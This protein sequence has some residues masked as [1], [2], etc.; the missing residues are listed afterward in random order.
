MSLRADVTVAPEVSGPAVPVAAVRT[1]P[2]GS[3]WV[4]LADGT[5][6]QVTV[7]GSAGGVAVVDGLS[8]GDLVR[9]VGGDNDGGGPDS[10]PAGGH[11]AGG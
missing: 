9:V 6:Q 3:A 1:D 4:R 8:A 2:D 7:L 11:G 5:R 10:A